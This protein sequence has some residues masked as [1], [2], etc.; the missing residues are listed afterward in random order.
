MFG[1]TD[2]NIGMHIFLFRGSDV[3]FCAFSYVTR[4]SVVMESLFMSP[5]V[6]SLLFWSAAFLL[7]VQ[8]VLAVAVACVPDLGLHGDCTRLCLQAFSTKCSPK[9]CLCHLFTDQSFRDDGNVLGL[10]FVASANPFSPGG[11]CSQGGWDSPFVPV[12]VVVLTVSS[13]LSFSAC[14]LNTSKAWHFLYV[15]LC[16]TLELGYV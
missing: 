8:L 13:L 2:W 11:I 16:S 3:L 1:G 14:A 15:W 9:K 5:H 12:A 6:L 4:K 7:P 10:G